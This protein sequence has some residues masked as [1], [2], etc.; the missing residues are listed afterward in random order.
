[1]QAC[2]IGIWSVLCFQKGMQCLMFF[3]GL[4]VGFVILAIGMFN[5]V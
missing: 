2:I 5:N 4:D 1:M 3:V